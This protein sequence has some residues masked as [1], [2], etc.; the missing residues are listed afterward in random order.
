LLYTF[1]WIIPRR[2]NFLCERFG[3]LCLWR[4]NKQSIPKCWHIKFRSRGI[5]QKKS[6]SIRIKAKVWNYKFSLPCKNIQ[7]LMPNLRP[8]NLVYTLPVYSLRLTS[9]S[10]FH[11]HLCRRICL[12]PSDFPTK[13]FYAS[14]C[15]TFILIPHPSRRHWFDDPNDTYLVQTI[16]CRFLHHATC[17]SFLHLPPSYTIFLR[18][19]LSSTLILCVCYSIITLLL[20]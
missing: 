15:F 3:T 16:H 4:W 1:F 14:L 12:F 8:I 5:T 17:V 20:S 6:Y 11:L 19:R 2:L 18:T 7:P 9:F 13:I 10:F